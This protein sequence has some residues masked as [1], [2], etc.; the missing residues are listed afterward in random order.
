MNVSFLMMFALASSHPSQP[1]PADAARQLITNDA[2]D[3]ESGIECISV[4]GTDPSPSL[5]ATIKKS[6]PLAAPK[7][8]CTAPSQYVI[9]KPS[10]KHVPIIS[11]YDFKQISSTKA[12]AQ[13]SI[14]A[15]PLTGNWFRA[16][17]VLSGS[18][19]K[20]IKVESYMES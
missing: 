4:D 8:E 9:H 11:V 18:E 14:D 17:F 3:F 2:K 15:G 5:M 7:S 16:T 20:L 19:W 13:Y 6:L 10:G 12:T 1:F